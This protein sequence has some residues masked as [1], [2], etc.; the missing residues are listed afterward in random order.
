MSDLMNTLANTKT[1]QKPTKRN[2]WAALCS[3]FGAI[4][5]EEA[6][7]SADLAMLY[8][9][10]RPAPPK[11]PK[12]WWQWV[13]K[14]AEAAAKA[15]DLRWYLRYVRVTDEYAESTDGHRIHRVPALLI[16]AEPG[17]YHPT[18]ERLDPE[19]EQTIQ[20]PDTSRLW[21]REDTPVAYS[22]S[23]HQEGVKGGMIMHYAPAHPS[24]H[25]TA[26]AERYATEATGAPTNA[27]PMTFSA[28]DRESQPALFVVR[29]AEGASALTMPVRT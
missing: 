10:F 12:T 15:N 29:Y 11:N 1:G 2:A 28:K 7:K 14:P 5:A 20:Y 26:V 9:H 4:E 16:D 27:E 8:H 18:G 17:F 23:A 24:G 6:P 13:A 3:V 25:H 22:H 19:S 21:P